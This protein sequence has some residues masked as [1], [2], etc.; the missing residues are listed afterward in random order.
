MNEK[1]QHNLE[2]FVMVIGTLFV[3]YIFLLFTSAFIWESGSQK[4]TTNEIT[5]CEDKNGDLIAN[6]TCYKQIECS[7]NLKFLNREECEG[8]LK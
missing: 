3:V 2:V 5:T 4:Y 1:R 8:L 6:Q 7:T